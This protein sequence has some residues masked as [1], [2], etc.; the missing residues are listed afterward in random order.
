MEFLLQMFADFLGT[1]D[2][3]EENAKTEKVKEKEINTKAAPVGEEI[4]EKEPVIFG[5]MQFH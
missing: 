2:V 5:L 3:V 4:N 1:P